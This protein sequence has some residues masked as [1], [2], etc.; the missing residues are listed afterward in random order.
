VAV[1]GDSA[2]ANLAAVVA[3]S[4]GR[5]PAFALL[6]YPRVDL[7]VQRRSHDLFRTGYLLT[8]RSIENFETLYIQPEHES[9]PRAS[10]L[11]TEDL[12]AFPPTYLSTAGFDPLRDEGEAFAARLADAGVPVVLSRHPDLI[13]GYA[14]LFPL[15]GRFQEATAEAAAAL[16]T[17]LALRLAHQA[18]ESSPHRERRGDRT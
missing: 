1:G 17:G 13:H 2:G 18:T 10:V 4:P 7:T 3:A 6:L 8:A 14:S 16:R 11:L 15:G 5:Q 12:A 9:D